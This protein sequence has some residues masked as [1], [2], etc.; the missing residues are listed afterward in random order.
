MNTAQDPTPTRSLHRFRNKLGVWAGQSVHAAMRLLGRQSTALPGYVAERLGM[1]PLDQIMQERSYRHRILVTGTNGKT[2]TTLLMKNILRAAGYQVV[3]NSS[4]SNLYRGVLSSLLKD[5]QQGVMTVL[6]LEVDEAS[7]TSVVQAVTPDTVIVL[8]LFRDQL[9]RY[10]EVD[11]TRKLLQ[12]ALSLVPEADIVLCAD[13]PHVARLGLERDP[14]NVHYFGIDAPGIQALVHDHAADV[15]VS[16]VTGS[17]LTYSQRFFGHLGHY[18]AKDK[19]F[20]RPLPGVSVKKVD[21]QRAQ[22]DITMNKKHHKISSNLVGI[23]NA[24]NISAALFTSKILDIDTEKAILAIEKST[25]GFGRQEIITYQ[26][27][28]Y[29]FFLIKNPTG[30]NQVIQSHLLALKGKST[31]VVFIINDNFA[32]GRDVSWLWDTACEDLPRDLKLI[33]S[34]TRA[35]DMA[36]RLTDAG[37]H[38]QVEEDVTQALR[39]AGDLSEGQVSVLPTYTALLGIRKKLKLKLEHA[40]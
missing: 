21:S 24:Y 33:V 34:G 15:P 36:L 3:N 27:V 32:D 35:Y 17:A 10:G 22:F 25:A 9:D 26:D 4:G 12:Q 16:P 14:Q 29:Q 2:T 23:Y 31:P 38:C 7:M 40:S 1:D 19:S 28:A 37:L 30:F 20:S 11:S 18:A 13:D 39:T 5:K 8:N 6:L